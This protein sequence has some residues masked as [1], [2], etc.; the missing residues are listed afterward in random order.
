MRNSYYR[1]WQNLTSNLTQFIHI[2]KNH[3]VITHCDVNYHR[4][5]ITF[6]CECV[7]IAESNLRPTGLWSLDKLKNLL[8]DKL[9]NLNKPLLKSHGN[10]NIMP[11]DQSTSSKRYIMYPFRIH[12]HFYFSLDL[13]ST[14]ATGRVPYQ[15][16]TRGAATDIVA[17]TLVPRM[18]D[19]FL[20]FFFIYLFLFF[21]FSPTWLRFMLIWAKPGR[22]GLNRAD[23]AKIKLYLPIWIVSVDSRNWPKWWK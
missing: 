22:F 11:I 14:D 5:K 6:M 17:H 1:I 3:V 13:G 7:T 2:L 12:I 18:S 8:L 16:L 20:K 4:D 10:Y 15:S 9:K 23:S 21:R 19:F